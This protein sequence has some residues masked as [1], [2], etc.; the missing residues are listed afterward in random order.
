MLIIENDLEYQR[1]D[2]FKSF[3]E[4]QKAIEEDKGNPFI[5]KYQLAESFMKQVAFKLGKM[6]KFGA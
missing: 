6:E 1:I 5:Y 4:I 3:E 2:H